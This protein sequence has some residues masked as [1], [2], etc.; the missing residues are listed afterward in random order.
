MGSPSGGPTD[1]VSTFLVERYW[2]GTSA[3]EVRSA[4]ARETR[5]ADELRQAGRPVRYLRSTFMPA[6][7]AL[8]CLF[9]AGSSEEVADVNRRASVPFDRI[10]EVIVFGPEESI[11]SH[12]QGG[13]T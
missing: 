1:P 7:D 8:L 13:A 5:S 6:E 12:E 9:E 2:P 10:V 4:V 11:A 3:A